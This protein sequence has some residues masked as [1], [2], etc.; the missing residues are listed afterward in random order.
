MVAHPFRNHFTKPSHGD[1]ILCLV[2]NRFHLHE[3]LLIN[4]L[5]TDCLQANSHTH[6]GTNMGIH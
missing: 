6:F 4:N 1:G 2:S 5:P 3:L